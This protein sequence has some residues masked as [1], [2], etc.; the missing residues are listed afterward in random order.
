MESSMSCS[1]DI[2]SNMV[3]HGLQGD[4]LLHHGSA[5]PEPQGRD[6]GNE[7]PPIIGED[8]VR[9]H[10]RNLNIHKSVG[11]DEMCPM[12]LRELADV[13][14]KL[15]FVIFEKSWQSDQVPSDQRKGNITAIF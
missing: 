12:V 15:F 1:V 9:D 6:W 13:V 4:N 10:L 7:V 11:C 8:Q 3:L 5:G 2:C 14:V